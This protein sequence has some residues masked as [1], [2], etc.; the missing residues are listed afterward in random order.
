[1]QSILVYSGRCAEGPRGALLCTGIRLVSASSARAARPPQ[2]GQD[3]RT[4][5]KQNVGG[6]KNLLESPRVQ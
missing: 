5:V 6:S 1:M 2:E 3:L 4:H